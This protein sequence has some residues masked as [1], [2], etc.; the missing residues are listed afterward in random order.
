M[1]ATDPKSALNRHMRGTN[2]AFS[3]S[4]SFSTVLIAS[5]AAALRSRRC[6]FKGPA[7][8]YLSINGDLDAPLSFLLPVLKCVNRRGLRSNLN[9]VLASFVFCVAASVNLFPKTVTVSRSLGRRW[10]R[11]MGDKQ[12]QGWEKTC[13]MTFAALPIRGGLTIL[14]NPPTSL[15]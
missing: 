12:D 4:L 8:S 15:T 7:K 9:I 6:L 14:A 2:S 10:P 5:A 11:A 3:T 1:A 13:K